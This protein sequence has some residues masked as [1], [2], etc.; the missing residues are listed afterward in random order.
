MKH[1]IL[2]VLFLTSHL[3]AQS[4][5]IYLQGTL[6]QAGKISNY[7]YHQITWNT[8]THK[9]VIKSKNFPSLFQ[10]SYDT[11]SGSFIGTNQ[12]Q[13]IKVNTPT[14]E[15]ITVTTCKNEALGRRYGS[16]LSPNSKEIAYIVHQDIKSIHEPRGYKLVITSQ[17]GTN[18]QVLFESTTQI[19]TDPYWSPDG[20]YLYFFMGSMTLFDIPENSSVPGFSL[21][22]INRNG[23]NLKTILSAGKFY[24]AYG[25]NPIIINPD[26][27]T[28]AIYGSYDPSNIRYGLY[29]LNHDG[30]GLKL[31]KE[32]VRQSTW[33]PDGKW[34]AF[35][36][37][38]DIWRVNKQ[39]KE[40]QQLTHGEEFAE[41]P[42]W[43]PDGKYLLFVNSK[44]LP[45][46]ADNR[47][48]KLFLIKLE[49]KTK[50][51][52]STAFYNITGS[53]IIWTK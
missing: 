18:N 17:D 36:A 24:R 11:I 22:R 32:E 40:L 9:P 35:S 21:M 12:G 19:I 31:I 44:T 52:L 47:N 7:S 2:T 20:K 13:I 15:N 30:T 26:G 10:W 16:R 45:G 48:A 14:K 25:Q 33:S 38:G 34:L 51:V 29:L 23:T 41:N 3:F 5:N 39:G 6:T 28:M 4:G 1:I 46:I 8:K 49:S 42:V 43:S 27:N 53:S 37:D 50:T